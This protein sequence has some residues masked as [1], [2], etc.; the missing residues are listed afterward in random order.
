LHQQSARLSHAGLQRTIRDSSHNMQ[1]DA[2]GAVSAAVVEV[3][4]Q[5]RG[6][7]PIASRPQQGTGI[8]LLRR[9]AF[10]AQAKGRSAATIW[11]DRS[12]STMRSSRRWGPSREGRMTTAAWSICTRAPCS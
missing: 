3:L 10:D 7:K 12:Y 5:L 2:P 6:R 8:L 9:A 1:L 4:A 11:F